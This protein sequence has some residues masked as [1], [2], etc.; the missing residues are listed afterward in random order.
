[1][2]YGMV[3]LKTG[4]MSTR[5]GNVIRVNDLL[6][7]AIS[8]VEKIIDEKN[9]NMENKYEN[10]KK[11]GIGAITFSN[12]GTTIIKDQIF[13]WDTIL[14]FNGETGPYVQYIYVRTRSVLE[15][16]NCA[17]DYE[18]AD[19]SK[20]KEKEEL[21]VIKLLYNFSDTVVLAA[22]KNEPSII[23]RYLI[24]LAQS[25]SRFYNEH[26]I[27]CEDIETK[28]ARVALTKRVG[29][30]IK[31]GLSLLGISTPEKM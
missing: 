9:P 1:M 24:D 16:A 20:I 7:E 6:N 26:Q 29:I 27:I 15:K 4:K 18:N 8:R 31:S 3:Q 2:Q 30:V 21:D 25:F 11:I 17:L 5:E 12:V 19:Y 14:N 10:A 22:S 23:A 28:E 13:D